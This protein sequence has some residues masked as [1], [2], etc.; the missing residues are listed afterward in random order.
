M[1]YPAPVRDILLCMAEEGLY[2]PKWSD[3][4][5]E[6][7]K[8]NVLINRPD[9]KASQLNRTIQMMNR[10]FRDAEITKYHTLIDSLRLPDPDDRH[11]LAAA[12]RC[13]ADVIVTFNLKDFPTDILREFDIEPVHPDQF[14]LNLIDLDEERAMK[15]FRQQISQLANPPKSAQE[16]LEILHNNG[17]ELTTKRLLGKLFG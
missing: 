13:N 4:I 10:A 2:R 3:T 12:I 6:E 5:Q 8:R 9:L 15:A 16:V 17:L 11:V 14:I 1:L 7:W